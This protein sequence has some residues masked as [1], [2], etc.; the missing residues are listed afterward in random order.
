MKKL[1]A[2]ALLGCSFLLASSLHAQD[3]SKRASPPDKVTKK[4]R[5]GAT[6]SIDYSQ[7]SL[8]GRTIG[9][10]VEPMK[11]SIWRMGAN[12]ATVFET[13]RNVKIEGQ[14]L[15]AGKY[16]LFGLWTDDGFTLI[17]NKAWNIWGTNYKQNSDKDALK[18]T[19]KP[20]NNAETREKLA[21]TIDEWGK[22]SMYWGNLEVD[23]HVQ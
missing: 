3:K 23:F 2:I 16:S 22:V 8:K 6:I 10:N 1:F 20:V 17:F 18:V 11:D 19:V 12:E 9:T 21:Y 15:P 4:I 7:P 5:S 13:D 14:D